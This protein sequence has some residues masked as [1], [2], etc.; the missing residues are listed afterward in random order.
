LQASG[1]GR[2][3]RKLWCRKTPLL[4]GVQKHSPLDPEAP[5]RV[6]EHAHR[7]YAS[8]PFP[9]STSKVGFRLSSPKPTSRGR[10]RPRCT[11]GFGRFRA[12]SGGFARFSWGVFRVGGEIPRPASKINFAWG[13]PG[14]ESPRLHGLQ[15]KASEFLFLLGS[16]KS[17]CP[18]LAWPE[19]PFL[20]FLDGIKSGRC[21]QILTCHVG[22]TLGQIK[23][24][25]VLPGA[26]CVVVPL[27]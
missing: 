23:I 5:T 21:A 15:T 20:A 12:V 24:F 26:L 2:V 4:R 3:S 7:W 10:L 14:A 8:R 1:G 13:A 27:Q 25:L 18:F 6:A 16:H 9:K 22:R 17:P 11:V 19:L